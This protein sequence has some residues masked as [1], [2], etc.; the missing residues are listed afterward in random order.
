[1][2]DGGDAEAADYLGVGEG[3]EV[4]T[5]L[6]H[7]SMCIG[8]VSAGVGAYLV[9]RQALRS[10]QM[11]GPGHDSLLCALT[12]PTQPLLLEYSDY[13]VVYGRAVAVLVVCGTTR[14]TEYYAVVGRIHVAVTCLAL[15]REQCLGRLPPL[16]ALRGFGDGGHECHGLV[17]AAAGLCARG[18]RGVR[19]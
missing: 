12:R 6:L 16:D 8:M 17:H 10:Y 7:V 9:Y 19:I 1:V 4:C 2:A 3:G 18:E 15:G 5:F 13:L 11:L 14:I